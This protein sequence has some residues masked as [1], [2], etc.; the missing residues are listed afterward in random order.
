MIVVDASFIVA[1]LVD[2]GSDGTWAESLLARDGLAAPH[3]MPVEVAN[4]L[5]RSVQSGDISD[6]AAS[7]AQENLM[8]LAIE[9]FPYE[10][11]A[12]RVWE[13]KG[14]LTAYDAWYVAVAESLG[15][16]LATVDLRLSRAPGPRC[17]FLT[18]A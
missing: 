10:P 4:I 17:A 3:L 8:A 5:R 14:N 1:A 18:P 16:K 13:L 9:L 6:G 12:A 2:G 15:A 11:F 7:A